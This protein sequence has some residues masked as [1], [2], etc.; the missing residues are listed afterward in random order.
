MALTGTTAELKAKILAEALPYIQRFHGKTVV[1]KYGGNAMTDTALKKSFA[2][3]IVALNA[4]GLAPVVVHGGGPQISAMLKKLS[5]EG[6]FR[7]G[8]RVTT[9]EVAQV[10][11][12]VLAGEVRSEIV[13]LVNSSGGRAVG[14]GGDDGSLFV[15]AKRK[16]LVDGVQTDIGLV[17]DVVKVNG[18]II[19]SLLAAG[20][21][22]VV[23]S[24]ASD[25]DGQVLNVN[26]DTAAGTLAGAL[27]ATTLVMLTDVPGLYTQ[28]PDETSFVAAI[29]VDD[30]RE[31]LPSL[32]EG[33]V[34][35]IEAALNAL[36]AGVKEVRIVDGRIPGIIHLAL[37]GAAG[38][39][40]S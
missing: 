28:W 21:T 38:T 11:R 16:V 30:A 24:Y 34:P 18:T 23:S 29:S 26:A 32:S 35:K 13:A 27:S 5:L 15:A 19:H 10:V 9:A 4:E 22:P 7:G 37:S 1:I 14:V 33:M 31:L 36:A 17:G 8:Y 39:V 12:T 40:I 25:S 2:S 6:E 3:E 20:F